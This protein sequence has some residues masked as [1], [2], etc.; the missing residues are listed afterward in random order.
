MNSPDRSALHIIEWEPTAWTPG[1]QVAIQRGDLASHNDLAN[2]LQ[3]VLM[4]QL[5]DSL[6]LSLLLQGITLKF[7]LLYGP[8]H[9]FVQLFF[10]DN[11]RRL[12]RVFH[13][14]VRNFVNGFYFNI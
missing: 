3:K 4:A 2:F 8:L 5:L 10:C 6:P 13:Y 7:R 9:K 14:I 11:S 12:A 1:S